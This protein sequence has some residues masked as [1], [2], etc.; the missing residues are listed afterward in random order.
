VINVEKRKNVLESIH[1]NL[2]VKK[3]A[4]V[5]R[6]NVVKLFVVQL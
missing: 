5:S 1:V 4:N 6:L 3:F 2:N